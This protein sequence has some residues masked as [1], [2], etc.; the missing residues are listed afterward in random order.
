MTVRAE[1]ALPQPELGRALVAAGVAVTLL[2]A[3]WAMLH[4]GFYRDVIFD[5]RVVYHRYGAL[6]SDGGVPYRDFDVEYPPAAL[7]AFALPSLAG[8][9]SYNAVFEGLMAA[10]A[11]ATLCFGILALRELRAEGRRI[12][13]A[14]AFAALAPL[15]LGSIVLARF[16]LWPAALTVATLAAL[17]AERYRVGL[18]VLG[19]AVAAKLYPLALLPLALAYV[20]RRRGRR[21]ALL[22]LGSFAGVVAASFAPFLIVS[23][24]GVVD[25]ISGQLGRPLQ[26]ESLG[27]G[28]LL[29]LHHVAGLDVVMKTSHGSQNLDGTGTVAAALLLSVL[30]LGTLLGIWTWFARGAAE[31]ERLL[32][33][34]AAALVAFVALGKVLSPQFLIWLIPIVPL[35][36]G[37][38]GVAAS[39]VLAGALVLTQLW[40]PKRYLELAYE[41]GETVS[42]FVLARDVTLLA[43]LVVL[44]WP[45]PARS[46]AAPAR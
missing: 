22:A 38:R 5:D 11:A 7:P 23:P 43:L 12:A 24:G 4:V 10:C 32:R 13:A 31:P 26:I 1:R 28:V 6:I 3:A 18:A 9:A 14:G 19:L 8:D 25:S 35:V 21:E 29:V 40:F 46:E 36:R 15:A 30:Q 16:D 2:L 27:A 42:W 20:Y 34:S 39:T 17:L 37:R 45:T 33:A 44:L 41:L